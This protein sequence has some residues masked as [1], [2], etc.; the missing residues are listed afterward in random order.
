MLFDS[1]WQIQ[2]WQFQIQSSFSL[3][4]PHLQA[5]LLL[6]PSRVYVSMCVFM[7]MYMCAP[8]FSLAKFYAS[9]SL[10]SLSLSSHPLSLFFSL[11]LLACKSVF[12]S[13]LHLVCYYMVLKRMLIYINRV[14]SAIGME[15]P[16]LGTPTDSWANGPA[17]MNRSE[18]RG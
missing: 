8:L 12:P 11:S 4:W 1:K 9:T 13:F 10:S 6:S 2:L 15:Y 14:T 16:I 17:L 5:P 3:P 18:T 7:R